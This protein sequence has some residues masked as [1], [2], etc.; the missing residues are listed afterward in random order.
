MMFIEFGAVSSSITGVLL[1]VFTEILLY[2]VSVEIFR[3]ACFV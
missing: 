1:L 2:S 3:T